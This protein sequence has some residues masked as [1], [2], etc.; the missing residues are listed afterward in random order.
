MAVTAE[1]KAKTCRLNSSPTDIDASKRNPGNGIN[2]IKEPKKFSSAK[3][4]Y[5]TSGENGNRAEKSTVKPPSRDYL[6][7]SN[8]LLKKNN[9][10]I[11][12]I[13]SF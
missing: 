4:K 10:T 7:K 11:I 9:Y 1:I 3:P 13:S 5:P 8:E 6:L 2:G 12:K